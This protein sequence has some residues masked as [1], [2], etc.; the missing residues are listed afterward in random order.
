V[1]PTISKVVYILLLRGVSGCGSAIYPIGYKNKNQSKIYIN[2][3]TLS[4]FHH[5]A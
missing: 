2:C 3:G 1:C 4:R 5:F